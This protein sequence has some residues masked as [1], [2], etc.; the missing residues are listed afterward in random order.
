MCD[1]PFTLNQA[2]W[3]WADT[4]VPDDGLNRY[5]CFRRE[6]TL[7]PD[8]TDGKA[9]L[10]IAA[11]SNYAVWCNGAFVDCGQ[12]SN[13][14]DDKTY[15]TLTISPWLNAGKNA[16]CIL[17]H[18]WGESNF[19]YLRGEPG[20]LYAMQIGRQV[21]VSDEKTLCR[22]SRAYHQGPIYQTTPQ[23]GFSYAY[24][25]A[26]EDPWLQPD[27]TAGQPDWQPARPM[28]EPARFYQTRLRPRPLPKLIL[29]DPVHSRLIAQGTFIRDAGGAATPAESVQHDLLA[30]CLRKDLFTAASYPLPGSDADLP[31]VL[32]DAASGLTVKPEMIRKDRG[33]YFLFD[34]GREEVGFLDLDLD[35]DTGTIIDIAHGEHL[36]DLRV[37]ATVGG[38]HFA[39][40][41]VCRGGRQHFSACFRRIG[42]RYL[43]LHILPA[44]RR[45]ILHQ[46]SVRP[47]VY[48][49]VERGSFQCSD[50]LHNRIYEISRRT[51]LLCMHEHY[52]DCPWRE[53]A[54]YAMDSRNQAL[55][56]YYSFGE[57]EFPAVSFALLGDSLQ[58]DGLLEL[59]APS[60]FE[61]TI[62]SFSLAWVI[63]VWEHY[64]YSGRIDVMQARMPAVKKVLT[65]LLS[66]M[67]N[68][69]LPALNGKRYWNFYEWSDGLSGQD[70]PLLRGQPDLLRYDAPLNLFFLL[71]IQAA[72]KMALSLADNIWADELARTAASLAGQIHRQFWQENRRCYQTYRYFTAGAEHQK[73]HFAELTQALALYAGV[74]PA[75]LADDLRRTL[76]LGHTDLVPV[77]LSHSIYKY[78]ALLAQ[79]DRYAGLVFDHIARDWGYML[80][81]GATSFWETIKGSSDFDQAGSL[82]HGWSAIPV[83][84]YQAY[85]LGVKPLEPGF[86]LT[87]VKPLTALF[88]AFSGQVPTPAGPISVNWNAV[89]GT[90][91]LQVKAPEGITLQAPEHG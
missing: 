18:Y 14:P 9:D 75:D 20:L 53:Q 44:G 21:M 79:P 25:A 85:V 65:T 50:S 82:C 26:A 22:F 57:Y 90:P 52:E 64:L 86:R 58:P 49:L 56:G 77:T 42:C 31:P 83:Y 36:D 59:I 29:E 47:T 12:F 16:L 33:I 30:A 63:E 71:A 41:Y 24:D 34:L 10:Y 51:L 15:D 60:A 8:W 32:S 66:A 27:Y 76:A 62:P 55:C 23:L 1:E 5:V 43:E 67:K 46:A 70:D 69:L 39:A 84:L 81:Q 73:Q 68:G 91:G 35:T 28:K 88:P 89:S 45:L 13:F 2:A 78:E 7:S 40:R 6:F 80:Y 19:S 74:C 72:A 11:D 38:R 87:A 37:R 4:P 48:P 17:V 3:I 61:L 54:L